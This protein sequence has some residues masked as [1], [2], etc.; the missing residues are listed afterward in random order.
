M[1]FNS[2]LL[3]AL[4]VFGV[5]TRVQATGD[6][7]LEEA[8]A[9]EC[10]VARRERPW[11]FPFSLSRLPRAARLLALLALTPSPPASWL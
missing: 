1:R 5:A 11:P 2:A 3:V 9:S 6:A 4:L 8:I 10:I 7:A